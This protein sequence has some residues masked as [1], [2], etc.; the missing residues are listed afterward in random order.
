VPRAPTWVPVAVV[1]AGLPGL[2]CSGSRASGNLGAVNAPDAGTN[3]L[4][5]A[6]SGKIDILFDIDNSASMGDKQAYLVQAVPDLVGRLENPNCVDPSA[7]GAVL[8]AS[9]DGTCASGTLEFAPVRDMHLGIVTSSLGSRLSD[10]AQ[11]DSYGTVVCSPSASAP[12]PFQNVSAH[13]DDEG[14]LIARSLDYGTDGGN[15]TEGAVRDAVVAGYVPAPGGYLYWR[16]VSSAAGANDATAPGDAVTPVKDGLTLQADFQ[17]MVGGAG[18]FGCG[19]E[20]QLESWYR[21]L[22][23]PDPYATLAVAGGRA[24]WT[25]VDATLLRERHDFLR[26]DSLVAVIVL[27]DENDSE[28]DVRSLGREG[29][30]FMGSGYTPSPGTPAC[31]EDPADPACTVCTS[32][33]AG[34][35]GCGAPYSARNDWGFD[36]NLRHVHMKAKYGVDPQ[37][38]VQRYAIGLS[39]LLVP[40]R[41]GEYPNSSNNYVGMNDCVNPLFASALPDGSDT[42][43]GAVCNL[44]PGSRTPDLV[45]FAVIGGVPNQ[46]LHYMPGDPE[47][48]TLMPADWVRILGAGQASMT[49]SSPMSYD[50][51]GI[52]P[53]MIEDYRDRTTVAYPFPTD[54]SATGPLAPSASAPSA[55]DPVNGREWVT[56]Q[57]YPGPHVLAVDRQY[58][59]TF[60]LTEPRDCSLP[61]NADACDCPA[62]TGLAAAQVPPVCD[63]G[64]PT[65]QIAAKAYPT[66]RELLVAKL[67]GTQGIVSSICPTHVT[68]QSGGTDPFYGYRPAMSGIADRLARSLSP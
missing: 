51:T 55:P 24:E 45:Y 18:V 27:T 53:H 44:S 68:D 62:T 3:A 66:I 42:S 29:Y 9:I 13:N 23:Q 67:M 14:H 20:S 28:I 47:G 11:E 32:P 12:A 63:K 1:L 34:D 35:A 6:F 38:P 48:S 21:F 57:P 61:Q 59:C 5:T 41:S 17:Q 19:I 16:P 52:D 25:G 39:S 4:K 31:A 8:G 15:A 65:I 7:N 49:L 58:A 60:E 54:S 40:D 37:Y 64:D 46:L 43:P 33:G 26:P 56:D 50:Y 30:F 22:I 2:A 10:Q 36:L